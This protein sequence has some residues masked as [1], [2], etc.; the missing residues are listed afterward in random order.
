MPIPDLSDATWRK[1]THSSAQAQCVEIAHLPGLVG[2]RDS[3]QHV[4]T[5][6]LAFP[7]DAWS[8]FMNQWS[9]PRQTCH[10]VEV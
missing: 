8:T 1:S 6:V 7:A 2:L 5:P 10:I 3:K 9:A 4:T